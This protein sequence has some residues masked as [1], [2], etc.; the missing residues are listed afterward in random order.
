MFD[1]GQCRAYPNT[2]TRSVAL[3]LRA[4]NSR[5]CLFSFSECISEQTRKLGYVDMTPRRFYH[6][7]GS[8]PP[9]V[10]HPSPSRSALRCAAVIVLGFVFAAISAVAQTPDEVKP[11]DYVSDFAGVLS[12]AA[13]AQLSSLCAEV[14]QKTHAQIAVVTVK[15][16]EGQSIEDYTLTLATKWGVGPKQA[17]RG[18]MILVAIDDRLNRVEVGYGLEPILPD[19]KVGGFTREAA[20]Y[21]RS[22]DYDSAILL[23]TRRVADVIATDSGVTLTGAS[24]RAAR[25]ASAEDHG[26]T[27]GQIILLLIA[28]FFVYSIISKSSGGGGRYGRGGGS[29]WWIGPMIGS[30]M[31]GRGGWGGGGFGGGGGGGGGGFGGFGGGSFGGGGATG[32][33]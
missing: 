11:H 19:G 10:R 15:S 26:W 13:K 31:G 1:F 9:I 32:S 4:D 27:A 5:P 24:P 3:R 23:I 7:A 14:E 20:P 25:D 2:R 28:I 22:Q 29:G 21:F 6:C 8:K 16:L 30:G 33:W 12:P 17:A 18:V